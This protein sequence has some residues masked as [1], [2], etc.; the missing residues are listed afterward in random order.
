M[1]DSQNH[2]DQPDRIDQELARLRERRRDEQLALWSL[3]MTSYHRRGDDLAR[4]L[5]RILAG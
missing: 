4:E 2:Q 3:Q 5:Q 1:T